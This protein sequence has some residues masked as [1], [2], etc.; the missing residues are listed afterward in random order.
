MTPKSATGRIPDVRRQMELKLSDLLPI[1]LTK[2]IGLARRCFVAIAVLSAIGA[3]G[4]GTGR[5]L[6]RRPAH[7]RLAPQSAAD[8]VA[9][10]DAD[11]QVSPASASVGSTEL[12]HDVAEPA[13]PA[14]SLAASHG[15]R[16]VWMEVTAY[17]PCAKC[18]GP[19]AAGI[20]ASG[21]DI[22]YNA[23]RFVAA[24]TSTLPFGTRLLIPGYDMQPVEVIDR[25][26]AIKGNRLDVFFPS[27]EEALE[28]GRRVVA[29]R[30]VE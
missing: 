15:G 12:L 10:R 23:G 8:R 3:A 24:D 27:H 13:A 19:N 22:T 14:M 16:M 7:S 30:V 26:G 9:V 18:C 1:P 5:T 4:V 6:D 29:V 25:G 28:W 2:V 11:R 17:C 21:K 20:T